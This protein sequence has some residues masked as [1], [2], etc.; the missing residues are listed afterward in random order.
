ME[1]KLA[2][3]GIHQ[4][5][6]QSLSESEV[7]KQKAFQEWSNSE[8]DKLVVAISK[9]NACTSHLAYSKSFVRIFRTHE[10]RA[11]LEKLNTKKI[12][13]KKLLALSQNSIN[14]LSFLAEKEKEKLP[15]IIENYTGERDFKELTEMIK[16]ETNSPT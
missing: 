6:L 12:D 10:G 11:I 4:L 2:R 7:H 3:L 14:K 13:Q 9:Y 1:E 16:N 5:T 15:V 8:R